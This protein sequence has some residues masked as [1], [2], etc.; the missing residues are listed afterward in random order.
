MKAK[1]RERLATSLFVIPFGMAVLAVVLAFATPTIGNWVSVPSIVSGDADSA[2]SVLSTIASSTIT[3]TALVFSV[4]MLVLQLASSQYTPR[5][6]RT[7][8]QDRNSQVTL[9]VF[10]STFAYSMLAIRGI[11]DDSDTALAVVVSIFLSL[12]SLAVF[13]QFIN[14]TA[15]KIRVSTITSSIAD[16]ACAAV[17]ATYPLADEVPRTLAPLAESPRVVPAASSG[18]V[19]AVDTR[20]LV[21]AARD[22][23]VV[24]RV[25]PRVGNFVPEGAPLL[26]VYG[27]EADDAG[28]ARAVAIGRERSLRQDIPFGLRQLVD[29]AERALSPGVNDPTTAVQCLDGIHS[30]LR[31]LAG[32]RPRDGL[33]ADD[34]ECVRAI[35]D[36]PTWQDFLDL[37]I[38]EI[39][40]YGARSIQVNARLRAL[41]ADLLTVTTGERSAAV[42]S[43]LAALSDPAAP[44]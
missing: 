40:H 37:A 8:L 43:K 1:L 35:I 16:E 29:I 9:G 26:E 24:V 20:T 2:R 15:Q 36:E 21:A 13:V 4:T 39:A 10:V 12:V 32:R 11:S 25:V 38:D 33:Y 31:T 30:V 18:V 42:R 41:L 44:A 22:A 19:V 5:V 17:M 3:L 6:L 7:F 28:L 34:E 27:R 23:G 14:H